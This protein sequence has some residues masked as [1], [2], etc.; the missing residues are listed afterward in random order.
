MTMNDLMTNESKTYYVVRTFVG[1]DGCKTLMYYKNEGFKHRVGDA[2]PPVLTDDL[3]EAYMFQSL[4][5]AN[6]YKEIIEKEYE[7]ETHIFSMTV[8]SRVKVHFDVQA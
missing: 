8:E 7:A 4:H 6:T 2:T 1:V 3:N 5:D